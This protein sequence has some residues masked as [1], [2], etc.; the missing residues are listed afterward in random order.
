MCYKMKRKPIFYARSFAKQW[1]HQR[2]IQMYQGDKRILEWN[3]RPNYDSTYIRTSFSTDSLFFE[4]KEVRIIESYSELENLGFKIIADTVTKE[5][6]WAG[7]QRF[8]Y[9]LT[10]RGS[11]E[12]ALAKIPDSHW[13]ELY[14]EKGYIRLR[15]PYAAKNG[16]GKPIPLKEVKKKKIGLVTETRPEEY[17]LKR[18]GII[19]KVL[20]DLR[21][22]RDEEE[23]ET[24]YIK[25]LPAIYTDDNQI[26]CVP[27]TLDE[28]TIGIVGLKRFGKT[29]LMHA[30]VDRV[31]WKPEWDASVLIANDRQYECGV[32]ALPNDEQMDRGNSDVYV[33][34]RINEYPRPLPIV[35][36][37][38]NTHTLKKLVNEKEVGFKISLPLREVLDNFSDFFKFGLSDRYFQ[39]FKKEL[40]DCRSIEEVD[41]F[42][43]KKVQNEEMNIKSKAK[44]MASLKPIFDLQFLDVTSGIPSEWKVKGE[45]M[46]IEGTFNPITAC[47][48]AGLVPV[49]ETKD[50]QNKSIY[51]H[52]YRYLLRDIFNRQN[53]DERFAK[54]KIWLFIDELHSISATDNKTVASEMLSMCVTEGGPNRIGTVAVDQFYARIEPKIRGQFTYLFTFANPYDAPLIAKTYG[55][56]RDTEII[57]KIQTLPKF[58]VMAF[59]SEYF[60]VYRG[61]G[62]SYKTKGPIEGWSFPPLSRHKKP[63]G[64]G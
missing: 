16:Y 4:E 64:E 30:F 57:R 39:D 60:V 22:Y 54:E 25:E 62:S 47:L 61:D 56:P 10:K 13:V 19:R 46:E 49:L 63:A 33:M 15:G 18:G 11:E 55:F 6:R 7:H 59:T 42:L 26:V 45:R 48:L 20:K 3:R 17:R 51:P 8:K 31:M 9:R 50:L 27:K 53:E 58:K 40:Y 28:P 34:R 5:T 21:G 36:L 14:K 32:W 44:L 37:H 35:N 1:L 2:N 38:P 43:K 29:T 23:A 41:S 24:I 52:Y 12:R